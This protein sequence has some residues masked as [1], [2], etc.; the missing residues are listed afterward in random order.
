MGVRRGPA[1]RE[2]V[3]F[4]S[5]T[6]ATLLDRTNENLRETCNRAKPLL[7]RDHGGRSTK[8]SSACG[9]RCRR[10]STGERWTSV[11]PDGGAC[12]R[13]CWSR[14]TSGCRPTSCSTGP[15]G[16]RVPPGDRNTPYGYL[17]RL[18]R[19]LRATE[20][21]ATVHRF[22]QL[23]A[24]AR[25]ETD[26][27]RALELAEAAAKLCWGE[28]LLGLD[29]P[30]I[31]SVRHGLE[32]ERFA[33]DTD[34]LDLALRLGRH[35]A[36]LPELTDR[37]AEHPLNEHVAAQLMLA[38]F[39]AGRQAEALDRYRRLRTRLADELGT[40]PGSDLRRP[41]HRILAADPDLASSGAD[42]SPVVPRQLRLHLLHRRHPPHAL[43]LSPLNRTPRSQTAVWGR[44][45]GVG[46]VEVPRA[47][48]RRRRR[49]GP[50][51]GP[52]VAVGHPRAGREPRDPAQLGSCRRTGAGR[53][54]RRCGGGPGGAATL[55]KRVAELEL[56]KDILR[57]AAA[58]FAKEMGR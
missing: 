56:E 2:L 57:K 45:F 32:Q 50:F 48:P 23:V 55:R 21:A 15:R 37:A 49:V 10:G 36:L 28:V 24:R 46:Q 18:R 44:M 11:T 5:A 14:P 35:A 22:R 33:A 17:S 43:R 38:L 39:R 1:C 19:A 26:Q 29:T 13:C 4:R 34:R 30:W 20:Q 51:V 53:T 27:V 9:A 41:R 40:E 6:S 16:D 12:W 31:T 3:P 47:V 7:D 54:G 42:R 25:V 8:G 58:Y 52:A